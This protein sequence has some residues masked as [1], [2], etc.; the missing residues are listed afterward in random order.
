MEFPQ[1]FKSKT[2]I[3][4]S[5]FTTRYLPQRHE[6]IC[7]HKNLYSNVHSNSNQNR[8]KVELTQMT[9]NWYMDKMRSLLTTEYYWAMKRSE[10]L[11]HATTWMNLEKFTRSERSQPQKTTPTYMKSSSAAVA[12]VTIIITDLS[13]WGSSPRK[14]EFTE[15]P[16]DV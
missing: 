8:Q 16:G 12:V 6:N 11:L 1:K 13:R 2:I 4:P 3:W 10:V 5:N 7:P 15:I 14:L 9:I